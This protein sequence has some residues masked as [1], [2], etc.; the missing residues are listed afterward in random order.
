MSGRPL[1]TGIHHGTRSRMED[2]RA[3][4]NE[5]LCA[6]AAPSEARILGPS[7]RPCRASERHTKKRACERQPPMGTHTHER[8]AQF[9][10]SLAALQFGRAPKLAI[11]AG[12]RERESRPRPETRSRG[13]PP[14][15]ESCSGLRLCLHCTLAY[16][17]ICW[18]AR[19]SDGDKEGGEA[20]VELG[21]EIMASNCRSKVEMRSQTCVCELS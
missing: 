8:S 17:P 19:M 5:R 18:A 20:A 6:A 11:W 15:R 3:L 12:R 2:A 4:A 13:R 21:A 9:E 14:Q 10:R 16:T 7:W 1:G